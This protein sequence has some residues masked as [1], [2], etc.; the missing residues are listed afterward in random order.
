[1]LTVPHLSSL[2]CT[3]SYSGVDSWFSFSHKGIYFEYYS[4]I[5][6]M[7]LTPSRSA[8]FQLPSSIN[9]EGGFKDGE[10]YKNCH[11][12]NTFYENLFSYVV[13]L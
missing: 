10:L 7:P 3:T 6:P 5:V 13:T 8:L 9:D 1:M 4:N 11:K 12:I 2:W